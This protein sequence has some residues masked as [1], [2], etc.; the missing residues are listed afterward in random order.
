MPFLILHLVMML[1]LTGRPH[2][3]LINSGSILLCAL[4]APEISPAERINGVGV[5]DVQPACIMY[6][7][8]LQ[9]LK[10][11]K[12]LSGGENISISMPM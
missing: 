12:R 11:Y 3:P 5:I 6:V 10:Q 1:L 7:H 2:N 8:I 4:H 9:M